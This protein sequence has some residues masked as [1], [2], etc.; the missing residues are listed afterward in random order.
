MRTAD[1]RTVPRLV[2]FTVSPGET[3]KRR[4]RA[5]LRTH[6]ARESVQTV[7]RFLVHVL[8]ALGGLLVV[9]VVFPAALRP[10]TRRALLVLWAVVAISAIVA[11]A[12]EWRL[13][14]KESRLLAEPE[15]DP[16]APRT[17]DR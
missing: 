1:Q 13:G 15:G 10:D 9:C 14:R 11:S 8:A 16:P 2:R 17:D 3:G 7:R 5:I 12:F 6:L 4:V